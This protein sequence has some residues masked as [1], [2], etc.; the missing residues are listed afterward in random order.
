MRQRFGLLGIACAALLLLPAGHGW[1]L[2]PCAAVEQSTEEVLS[3]PGVR[4]TWDASHV[5]ANAPDADIYELT[6]TV[7]NDASSAEPVTITGVRVMTTPRPLGRAPGG[8][9]SEVVGLP[10]GPVGPGQG[11][12][13][14]VRGGYRLAATDEGGRTNLHFLA[15]GEGMMSGQPF[16]LGI[17]ALLRAPGAAQD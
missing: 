15:E 12:T 13:F 8:G 17:N 5:C 6:V 11:A 1:A 10:T 2:Q 7:M 9:V 4:V 14:T 3:N 16:A